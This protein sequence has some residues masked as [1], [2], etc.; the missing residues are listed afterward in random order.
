MLKLYLVVLEGA[1][2]TY[3]HVV[4]RKK[5]IDSSNVSV[6]KIPIELAYGQN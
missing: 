5:K 2:P 4:E 1:E 3:D 6:K